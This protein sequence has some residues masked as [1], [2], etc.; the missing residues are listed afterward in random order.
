[1][2]KVITT[3]SEV[4][5]DHGTGGPV[6]LQAGQDVLTIGGAAVVARSIAGSTIGTGCTLTNSGAGQTPCS[7]V[8]S[9]LPGGDST[10][11][12]VNGTPVVLEGATGV[13]NGVGVPPPQLTWSV[14][15]VG[16]DVLNAD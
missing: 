15:S 11:L 8:V 10:V 1:M 5:C 14:K 6:T 13:T 16:Q 2:P 7:S 12:Q 4:K 9:Q 3:S